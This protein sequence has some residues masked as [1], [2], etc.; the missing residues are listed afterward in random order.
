MM[1]IRSLE[2]AALTLA[3]Y[4]KG[5]P[6][7]LLLTIIVIMSLCVANGLLELGSNE[8]CDDGNQVP[9]D[10]CSFNCEVEPGWSCVGRWRSMSICSEIT[11]CGNKHV[12]EGERCDYGNI[13]E[14]GCSRDCEVEQGWICILTNDGSTDCFKIPSKP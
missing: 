4:R 3:K 8:A 12:D 7:L 11:L 14:D 9:G 10:G 1:A 2:M 13:D 6:V 5:G